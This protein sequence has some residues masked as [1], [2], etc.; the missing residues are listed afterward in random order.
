VV[1]RARKLAE[2]TT[3][4]G[5]STI[6]RTLKNASAGGKTLLST[7]QPRKNPKTSTLPFRMATGLAT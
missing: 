6:T 5:S 7:T 4:Q 3:A 1:L 2:R